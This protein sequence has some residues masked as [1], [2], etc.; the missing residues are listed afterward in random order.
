MKEA[1]ES[2]VDEDRSMNCTSEDVRVAAAK[3]QRQG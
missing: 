3:N 2:K 1:K